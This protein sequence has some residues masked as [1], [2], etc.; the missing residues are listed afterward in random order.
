MISTNKARVLFALGGLIL[1]GM[2]CSPSNIPTAPTPPKPGNT[3]TITMTF[4]LTPLLSY[5]PSVTPTTTNTLTPTNTTTT[6]ATSTFTYP[7]GTHTPTQVF[8]N[9]STGTSTD[10]ATSTI[11]PTATIS[12]TSTNSA[13]PTVTSTITATGTPIIQPSALNTGDIAF[14]YIDCGGSGSAQYQGFVTFQPILTGTSIVFTDQS[15]SPGTGL[16][17]T[18][19]HSF[20]WTAPGNLSA[21]TT[22]GGTDVNCALAGKGDFC[23]AYQLNSGV[24]T[25]LAGIGGVGKAPAA[26]GWTIGGTVPLASPYDSYLPPA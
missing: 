15:Y 18:G 13:T 6:T 14:I 7:P 3:S 22:V 8:T 21:G 20:T 5:T 4:T 1:L 19:R 25:Y 9:T 16:S 2:A 23:I 12:Y 17:S 11:T 26:T 24:T 10:T